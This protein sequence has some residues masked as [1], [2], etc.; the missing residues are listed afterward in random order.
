MGSRFDLRAFHN[1][2]YCQI[3]S[4]GEQGEVFSH[5]YNRVTVDLDQYG[6][7]TRVSSHMKCFMSG[8]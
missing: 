7:V 3:N 4:L 2:C 5:F 6:L 8:A 1:L